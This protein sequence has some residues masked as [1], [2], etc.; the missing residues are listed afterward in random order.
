MATSTARQLIDCHPLG[1]GTLD[2][3]KLDAAICGLYEA[4]QATTANADAI[5]NANLLRDMKECLR[6]CLD[7]ADVCEAAA[8]VLSRCTGYDAAVTVQVL[9]AAVAVLAKCADECAR[10]ASMHMHCRLCSETCRRVEQTCGELL[11]VLED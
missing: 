8:K 1:Y 10:H 5:L 7:A 9:G 2:R 11:K 4:A 3:K 6:A